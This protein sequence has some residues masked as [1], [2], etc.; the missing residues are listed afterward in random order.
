[1]VVSPSLP[2][3]CSAENSSPIAFARRSCAGRI[4]VERAAGSRSTTVGVVSA[5][6]N[7]GAALRGGF[8]FLLTL[9]APNSAGQK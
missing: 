7:I 3:L 5:V 8:E 2:S 4:Y 1:M 9:V 6:L